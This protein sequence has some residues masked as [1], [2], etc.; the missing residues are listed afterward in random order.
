MGG[1]VGVGVGVFSWAGRLRR[2]ACPLSRSL[3]PRLHG[4]VQSCTW[5]QSGCHARRGMAREGNKVACLLYTVHWLPSLRVQPAK[6]AA[7]P[8]GAR[9]LAEQRGHGRLRARHRHLPAPAA[10]RAGGRAAARCAAEAEHRSPLPALATPFHPA[11]PSMQHCAR[12][13][14][15][16]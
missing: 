8:A 5:H 6:H 3:T 9:D 2:L 7:R 12:A 15:A 1:Q 13:P 16:V 14:R 4:C 10:A 11:S